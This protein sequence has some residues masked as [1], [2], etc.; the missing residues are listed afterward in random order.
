MFDLQLN[1]FYREVVEPQSIG[2]FSWKPKVFMDA[3]FSPVKELLKSIFKKRP[4]GLRNLIFLQVPINDTQQTL[5]NSFH[6]C[7]FRFLFT[8]LIGL[9]SRAMQFI[10][11]TL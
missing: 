3:L 10:M 5:G 2:K 7:P 6:R 4:Q 8:P 9:S 11:F 1:S